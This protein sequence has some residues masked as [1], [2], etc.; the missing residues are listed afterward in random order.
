MNESKALGSSLN[1][2]SGPIRVTFEGW[3]E[4]VLRVSPLPLALRGFVAFFIT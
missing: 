3:P 4:K 1:P 2:G